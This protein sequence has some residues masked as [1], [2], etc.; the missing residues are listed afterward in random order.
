MYG[1]PLLEPVNG[2]GGPISDAKLFF[3][4]EEGVGPPLPEPS[5]GPGD[6]IPQG[7]MAA[8]AQGP[9]PLGHCSSLLAGAG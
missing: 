9:H 5:S 6:L 7:L 2:Q 3:E 4:R 1:V 8:V